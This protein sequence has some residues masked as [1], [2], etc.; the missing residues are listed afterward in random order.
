MFPN[1]YSSDTHF[2]RLLR[3]TQIDH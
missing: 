2:V 1:I 3:M